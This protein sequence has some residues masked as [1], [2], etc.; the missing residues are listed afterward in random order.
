MERIGADGEAAFDLFVLNLAGVIFGN[1][2]SCGEEKELEAV[3][4][5]FATQV[6][7]P[8]FYGLPHGHEVPFFSISGRQL[9]SV[10]HR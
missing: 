1:F 6:N 9:I 4:K 5:D 2:T 8:V 7:C 10:Q 3:L